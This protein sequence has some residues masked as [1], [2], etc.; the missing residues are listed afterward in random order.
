MAR[1]RS[2]DQTTHWEWRWR[3][4]ALAAVVALLYSSFALVNTLTGTDL[5][6]GTESV[7]LARETFANGLE[8]IVDVDNHQLVLQG[9]DESTVGDSA[10]G[11][12]AAVAAYPDVRTALVT[13]NYT[14]IFHMHELAVDSWQNGDDF[15]IQVYGWDG[16]SSNLLGT[17]YTKQDTVN[18]SSI[19]GVTVSVDSGS[20]DQSALTYS[21][22]ISRQ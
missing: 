21:I 17:L 6:G 1:S 20:T 16:A 22:V 8:D 12:E 5:G 11:V 10:P 4:V 7:K 14:Y 15:T 2:A 19:E 18:N 9:S 3:I 13:N